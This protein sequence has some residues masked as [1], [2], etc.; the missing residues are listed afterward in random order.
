MFIVPAARMTRLRANGVLLPRAVIEKCHRVL[1]SASV[2]V[3]EDICHLAH[4]ADRCA[5]F[6]RGRQINE[7]DGRLCPASRSEKAVAIKRACLTTDA[8]IAFS[9]LPHLAFGVGKLDRGVRLHVGGATFAVRRGRAAVPILS[10]EASALGRV[11]TPPIS[12][13]ILG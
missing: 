13:T 6:E 4:V 3:A 2:P 7:I 10:G 12:A 8:P 9:H 11:W 5:I 1:G